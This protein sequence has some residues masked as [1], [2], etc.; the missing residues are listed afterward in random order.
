MHL[1]APFVGVAVDKGAEEYSCRA[2]EDG[3]SVYNCTLTTNE[4]T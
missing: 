4:N 1:D 3:T 2:A